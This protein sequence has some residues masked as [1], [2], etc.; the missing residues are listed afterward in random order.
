M[1]NEQNIEPYRFESG[2]KAREAG[3]KGGIA[4][5]KAKREKK[6]MRELAKI[7]LDSPAKGSAVKLARQFGADL[8][9]DDV[10]N[11]AAILAGQ[12]VAA[13][14]GNTNAAR[15]VVEIVDG[16]SRADAMEEDGLSKSLRELGESL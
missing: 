2:S 8:D 12:M 14:K 1:A 16:A 9:D 7:M 13:L 6:A 4:S 15:F 5:G 10:T 3:R 11:A